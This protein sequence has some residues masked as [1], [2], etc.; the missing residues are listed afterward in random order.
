MWELK[1]LN[2]AEHGLSGRGQVVRHKIRSQSL[3]NSVK[4][5]GKPLLWVYTG[6]P[7]GQFV[8]TKFVQA[9]I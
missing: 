3:V 9:V 8:F 1:K 6:Q 2:M 7:P 5:H 4:K